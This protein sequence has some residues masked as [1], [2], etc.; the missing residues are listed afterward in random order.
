MKFDLNLFEAQQIT[1]I[2]KNM[3]DINFNR[4]HFLIFRGWR[5]CSNEHIL[6]HR[7]LLWVAVNR[8]MKITL[9]SSENEKDLHYYYKYESVYLSRLMIMKV[10]MLHSNLSKQFHFLTIHYLTVTINCMYNEL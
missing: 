2:W 6:E 5:P 9:I 3:K 1:D 8:T 4:S 7:E 10:I